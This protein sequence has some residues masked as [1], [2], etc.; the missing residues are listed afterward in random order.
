LSNGSIRGGFLFGLLAILSPIIF[1][2]FLHH[3]FHALFDS[4]FPGTSSP[5]MGQ[6]KGLM[7]YILS[8]WE[9][10]FAWL[11]LI[12]TTTITISTLGIFYS[13]YDELFRLLSSWDNIKHIFTKEAIVWM[14]TATFIYHFEY[15]VRQRLLS[16]GY[17]RSN[18]SQ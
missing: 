8:W 12:L 18:R 2:A 15:L 14:V 10:L 9:G 7:P 5:E 17:D 16:V 4:L 13:S 3:F 1:I 11:V 6:V